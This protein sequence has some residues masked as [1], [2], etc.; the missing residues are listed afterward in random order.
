VKLNTPGKP[1][2]VRVVGG[3]KLEAARTDLHWHGAWGEYTINAV[4]L[5]NY[6]NCVGS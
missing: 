2:G 3:G 4:F 5:E 6:L 1:D